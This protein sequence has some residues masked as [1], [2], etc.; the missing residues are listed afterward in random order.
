MTKGIFSLMVLLTLGGLLMSVH[1]PAHADPHAGPWA[2]PWAE[3]TF[4]VG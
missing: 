2:G 4:Y 3:A 1:V